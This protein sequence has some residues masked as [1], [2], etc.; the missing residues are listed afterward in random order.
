MGVVFVMVFFW[1]LSV[2]VNVKIVVFFDDEVLGWDCWV[3][4]V[5]F[6]SFG[7][8]VVSVDD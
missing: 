5:R 1:I 3:V 4:G 2:V 6:R 7:E 8:L